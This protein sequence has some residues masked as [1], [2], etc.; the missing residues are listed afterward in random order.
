MSGDLLRTQVLV[1]GAGPAGLLLAGELRLGGAEVLVAE[2]LTEPTTESRASTLHAR[3]MEALDARG[4][5]EHFG[6]PPNEPLGH[7]GGIPLD[8]TLPSTHP[9]QWKILQAE[10]ER[11]LH[12]WSTGLGATV[13]R[14][15]ELRELTP[16]AD[17]VTAELAG[18]RGPVRVRAAYV[19]G[20]D[21]EQSAVRRL[22]G[23]R[24]T[25]ADAERE[26][27]RADV[28]GLDIVNRRFQRLPKGLAIAARRPD[29]VTRVMVHAFGTPAR[30]RTG[31]PDFAEIVAA[32]RGVTGE[33]IGHGTPL[34]VNSFDDAS[35]QAT[36]Y[37]RGR[38]LLAGDAAH[39]Q[40]PIGGQALNLA[41]QDALNLGWKLAAHLAGGAGEDLLDTYHGERHPV[42]R[43]VLGNIRAQAR[44]LLGGEEVEAVREVVGELAALP[45]ARAHLAA[46]IAG[47]DIAYPT[48]DDTGT[49]ADT[50]ASAL[51][52]RRLP[53]LRLAT[54]DG[55]VTTAGLLRTGRAV[56][57]DL[58]ADAT[59]RERRS[60]A[61]RPWRERVSY[62]AARPPAGTALTGTDAVLVRPDGYVA[63]VAAPGTPDPGEALRRWF[64]APDTRTASGVTRTAPAP[65]SPPTVTAP[66]AR[67]GHHTDRRNTM[68]TLT[69]KTA[70]VT[71]SSRGI[72]RATALR[73]A[74]EGALV[75]VHYTGNEEAAADV[76]RTIEKE[77]G[78]AFAVQAELGVPGDVH[79]LFLAVEQGLKE[80]TGGTDLNILVNNAGV[81]GGV[82]PE[83]TTPELFDRIMAVNAKAPFFIIQRALTLM[84]DGGR[85]INISTGLTKTANPQEIAY[86]MS[87]AAVEML[88]L[89]F[90]KHLGPR[91]ITINSVAPGITRN[92]NPV[93]DIP[94]AVEQMA[95]LS[96]FQRVGEPHDVGDIVALLASDDARWITG[97]FV[98]AS[99]GTLVG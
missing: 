50:G 89:H 3:T 22:G 37:R 76:V 15:H 23:F 92:G 46:M 36:E 61:V 70:L 55:T 57:L 88:A 6:T 28:A 20:C 78:R 11:V 45:P 59:R 71:G 94:E 17:H 38:V 4:L 35:R 51:L 49:D 73:L 7:F 87:K 48:A 25:G 60:A 96:V 85:I 19:V 39:R 33:D 2:R 13:L 27:L 9:G 80:R 81:M 97:S 44:L 16:A 42:G 98:D 10:V 24:F 52:G 47:L 31:A 32:W 68:G 53:P 84:P 72:G 5:L 90:A 40:M 8:L 79:E 99:G 64:A 77:G 65:H 41:L 66:G 91:G 18:P 43:R 93:F 30:R 75:V 83:D 67:A 21:G 29:G 56:L 86:A 63:W 74:R 82:A 34:W 26:L 62:V 58:S 12:G 54:P 95:Q 1:V 69:G 14:G